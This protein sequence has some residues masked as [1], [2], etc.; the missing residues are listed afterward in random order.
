MIL[1][2][3][4]FGLSLLGLACQ[5]P[6]DDSQHDTETDSAVKPPE[7]QLTITP[8]T[9]N[10]SVDWLLTSNTNDAF[11]IEGERTWF[12]TITHPIFG[13]GTSG[14]INFLP[15]LDPDNSMQA[16]YAEQNGEDS[17]VTEIVLRATLNGEVICEAETTVPF[18]ESDLLGNVWQATET[19]FEDGYQEIIGTSFYNNFGLYIVNNTS[20]EDGIVGYVV[21]E[22]LLTRQELHAYPLSYDDVYAVVPEIVNGLPSIASAQ[23]VGGRL[24]VMTE[25]MQD[26][27]RAGI[28]MIDLNGSVLSSSRVEYKEDPFLYPH[29]KIIQGEPTA[30]GTVL[31]SSLGWE[32]GKP[33]SGCTA[34]QMEVELETGGILNPTTWFRGQ[35]IFVAPSSYCNGNSLSPVGDNGTQYEAV[36]FPIDDMDGKASS[37]NHT[38]FVTIDRSAKSDGMPSYLFVREGYAAEF[39]LLDYPG[40]MIVELPNTPEGNAPM[41][42]IH[43]AKFWHI[44]GNEYIAITHNLM[45]DTPD[46]PARA[47]VFDVT[48][49]PDGTS[50]ALFRNEYVTEEKIEPDRYGNLITPEGSE[51]I[52]GVMVA[53][54]EASIWW[55]E[56]ITGELIGSSLQPSGENIEGKWIEVGNYTSLN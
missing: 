20:Q 39:D 54:N 25:S 6:K 11:V 49:N 44:G 51:D 1:A 27:F 26:M 53:E 33:R 17:L 9:G 3:V 12:K 14:T 46:G 43:D 5:K 21:V 4:I 52:M 16:D 41:N 10:G 22:D 50:Q 37:H 31:V 55:Y 23:I 36:T 19:T 18:A 28:F 15:R 7:C 8:K 56:L 45:S 42:F 29:H 38:F 34:I 32:P 13:T 30:D 48:I 24:M 35:D 40:L 2:P 47:Y